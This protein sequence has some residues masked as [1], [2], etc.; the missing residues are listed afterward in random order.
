ML[1]GNAAES[2][3]PVLFASPETVAQGWTC[4]KRDGQTV[5]FDPDKVRRALTNCFVSTYYA[6]VAPTHGEIEPVVEEVTR[7]AVVA[8]ASRGI[9][10]PTVE[11]VQQFVIQQLWVKGLFPAAEHYQNYRE[12]HRKKREL[13]TAT[14]F[15]RRVAFKPFDYADVSKFKDA[16][17]ESFWR[18]SEYD[19]TADIQDFKV[20]LLPCE[21]SAFSRTMLG[22]SQVEVA[23]KKFWTKL[24]DRM[25]RPEFEQVGVVFGES[26]VR[27]ADAYSRIL[28]VLDLN[29]AF[30]W[31][32]DV[33]AI[34]HRIE[35]L[36]R[37]LRVGA[38][39]SDKSFA[40]TIATFALLVEN[41]SLFSQFVIAKSFNK[42]KG[43]LTAVD[44]VVQ[45]TQKEEEVHALFGVWL[46]NL[47]KSERPDWF[48]KAFYADL[49]TTCIQ[50]YEAECGILNWIFEEGDI[51]T[52]S[53]PALAEFLK[54]RINTGVGMIGGDPVFEVDTSLLAE[55]AWFNEERRVPID[56]DFFHKN[57][58]NYTSHDRPIT[59][60]SMW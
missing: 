39:G 53:R 58:T 25:P 20:A 51:S 38:T 46:T 34:R 5:A 16:I 13:E 42:R 27:H 60:D 56:V 33:P 17:H 29:D 15:G 3:A 22:I 4:V 26:E 14:V 47:I 21:R 43:L 35:Y 55:T 54:D 2:C 6:G 18:G 40:K 48:D 28:D 19:F 50:A 31:V 37:A 52:V 41:V 10:R 23:V 9:E 49:R 7:A 30:F 8:I 44:T 1:R 59:A 24:G 36:N 45:A 57:P 12:E 11:Q 32:T